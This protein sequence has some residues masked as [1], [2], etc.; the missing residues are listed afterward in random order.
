MSMN[1]HEHFE[2]LMSASL[3][4]DLSDAE[5]QQLDSHLD[6]CADCRSTLAA[7]ADQR[8]I[9]A[10]LRHVAPPRDLGARVRTGVEGRA[11]LDVPW[12]RRP[13]VIFGGLGGGLAAVAG[14]LLAIVLLNG[15]PEEPQ[16]G[17]V[18]ELPSPSVSVVD[19]PSPIASVPATSSTP[20]ATEPL[21]T[22]VA[23]ATAPPAEPEA[24]PQ[25][26]VYLAYTGPFDNLQLTLRD[27]ETG[28]TLRE[29]DTPS[30]P[31]IAAQLSTNGQ[32]MAYIT[33]LGESGRNEV[34]LLHVGVDAAVR[35]NADAL[36]VDT[37]LPEGSTIPLGESI[38]GSEFLERLEWSPDSR[39]LAFTLAA[40]DA[41]GTDVWL[42]LPESGEVR[43]LTN[44][45]NAYTGSW[46]IGRDGT[47][48]LWVSVAGERPMSYVIGFA[49]EAEIPPP[50]DPAEQAVLVAE[51]V[52]QPLLSP[53]G[54]L[55]I[56]WRGVMERMGDEWLFA[57]GGAPYLAETGIDD[58]PR[59]LTNERP[60]FSDV[61]IDRDAF[62]SAAIAWGADSDAYAVWRAEWAG[63]PQGTGGE[64]PNINRVYFGHASDPRGLTE[65]HAIDQANIPEGASV[66]DVK[67][68]TGRHLA[69]TFR[70]PI[71]G[72]MD[73]P[74]AEL[75]L[76]VR[77][78]GGVPDAITSLPGG[79]Q[80]GWFG[81]AA[82][83]AYT[84]P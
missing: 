63:I 79:D 72:I 78:T 53:N 17:G 73:P 56:Y 12:W 70:M 5:R 67:V 60:L 8:R 47:S 80:F 1:R 18:T 52:F 77:N 2:E 76:V 13:V 34:Q 48:Y 58:Q 11:F 31:P 59:E 74:T 6:S 75:I 10:G 44:V 46:L 20:V 65:I 25:P 33:Q 61:I 30:G 4:G 3:S 7:F 54:S 71:G 27:G 35:Q 26:D 64:Y 23:T 29:L 68:P 51:G 14:A 36:V 37:P 39:Y 28:A 21:A 43:Q 55:A 57:E 49:D 69:I 40:T 9:M 62:T 15:A 16:V 66:V 81:P 82:Y 84:A 38:A 83:D 45:G 24:D 22:P 41:A 50:G 32:F 19:S 42:Y